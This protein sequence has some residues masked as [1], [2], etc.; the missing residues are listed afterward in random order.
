MLISKTCRFFGISR[1]TFVSGSVPIINT[2]KKWLVSSGYSNDPIMA[3]SND[4]GFGG[5]V[6]KPRQMQELKK[7]IHE[8][9]G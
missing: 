4:Y 7:V 1:D 9:L 3:N 8:V 6:E 5:A 2:D